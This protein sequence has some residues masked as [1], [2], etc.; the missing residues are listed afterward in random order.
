M[1]KIDEF[2]EVIKKET[3]IILAT[4]A[5]NRVTMRVVSPVMCDEGILFFT[6]S[7]SRKFAQ[8]RNN[9]K[10]CIAAGGFY[11][12]CEASFRGATM[13]DENS[14]LRAAY[15]VKFANAFD[16][17]VQYGG[18]GADF[19]VLKPTRLSGWAFKDGIPTEDGV[20][21]ETFDIEIN[22]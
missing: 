10:C 22:G 4:S 12:E 16:E 1:S 20:P 3:E 19:I 14:G 6:W 21:N 8:L 13:L 11:A 7:D 18:V 17:N 5:D 9:P 15:C 2:Y